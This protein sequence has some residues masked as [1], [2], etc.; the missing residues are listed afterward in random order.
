MNKGA[1][2][3]PE[4]CAPLTPLQDEKSN[5]MTLKK[6]PGSTAHLFYLCALND[7]GIVLFVL[8]TAAGEVFTHF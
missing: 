4:M 1:G 6:V 7:D 8:T 5:M 2:T 3:Q